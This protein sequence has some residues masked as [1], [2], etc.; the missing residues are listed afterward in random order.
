[1]VIEL[2]RAVYEG[3]LGC[4]WFSSCGLPEIPDVGLAVRPIQDASIAMAS[5]AS[6]SWRDARTHAQGELTGYLAKNDYSTYGTHWN[7]LARESEEL[8]RTLRSKVADSLV[9]RGLERHFAQSVL[10]DVGRAVLEISFR[11]RF[12]RAPVFFERLLEVYRAGHVP[13]G[14]D[15]ELDVWPQG[16]LL[17]H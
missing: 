16:T 4:P 8:D 17:V 1:M 6:A 14:W 13:C 15:G 10:V 5:L 2:D 11:K 12:K 3:L 9:A 7:K